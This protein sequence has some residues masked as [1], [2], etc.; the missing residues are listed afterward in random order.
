M[1]TRK[2]MILALALTV[3]TALNAQTS[4]SE[5]TTLYLMHSSGKHLERGTDDGGWIEAS[6]KTSPQ[7]MT[8]TPDGK[9]Y[10]TIQVA[11]QEKYLSLSGEWNSKFIA[12]GS[13]NEAKWTIEAGS[14]QY[15]KLRCKSNNTY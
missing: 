13:G 5:T 15:V 6:T 7:Q 14:G 2:M 10:Y 4:F 3:C 8:L 9:G 1:K 12:S 11:G